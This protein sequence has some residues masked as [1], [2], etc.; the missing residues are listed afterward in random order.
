MTN[1]AGD[2]AAPAS[3][4]RPIPPHQL[5]LLRHGQTEWAVAGK[6]TGLT[7]VPLTERGEELARATAKRLVGYDFSLVL[8]SP[9]QR[10]RRTAELVGLTDVQIDPNLVEWDYGGYEGLTTPEIRERLGYAWNVWQD[11]VVPGTASPGETIEQVSARARAVIDRVT[12]ALY[13]G[14][15]ALVAHGH[16]LRILAATWLRSEL[17]FGAQ[18]ILDAGSVSVLGYERENP[19]IKAWNIPAGD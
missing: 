3:G 7:D 4:N 6:H 9:L 11:G 19:A 5:V 15:V 12:P 2:Q 10:A 16:L 18:L 14:D 8:A 17:R 13:D 1:P